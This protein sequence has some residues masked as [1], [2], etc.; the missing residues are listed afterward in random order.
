MAIL[1]DTAESY[2]MLLAAN[3][4]MAAVT[5]TITPRYGGEACHHN[6]SIHIVSA[7]VCYEQ[8]R[9]YG[10]WRHGD[11]TNTY[12]SC[13]R[14]RYIGI[15]IIRQHWLF[16]IGEFVMLQRDGEWYC[17]HWRVIRDRVQHT[18][19]ARHCYYRW[20]GVCWHC[21]NGAIRSRHVTGY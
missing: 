16:A 2:E 14:R 18:N 10:Y 7:M 5:G 12:I 9:R 19:T 20:F 17:C 13:R 6:C 8:V 11:V 4:I 15:T 3:V 21:H 1:S